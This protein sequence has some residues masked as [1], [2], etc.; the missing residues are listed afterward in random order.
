M[1][2]Q[3]K[4]ALK[5]KADISSD[6]GR[7]DDRRFDKDLEALIKE[8]EDMRINRMKQ[9]RTRGFIA[10]NL[11]I[12]SVLIGVAAFG[13]FFLMEAQVTPAIV[14]LL[15]SFIPTAFVQVWAG[16][17][18]KTYTREHKSVFMPKLAQTLN[19][20]L[21]FHPERGVSAKILEK[22]AVVP[23]H[24]EY[25]AEDC[26]MGTYKGVKVI[27]SEARLYSK[28]H[29]DGA[30]FDGIFVLLETGEDV[31]DGHTIIT[32]NS[33]MVKSYAN[34]RW[35]TM[36]KVHISVSDPDWDKFHIYST[37]PEA[38]EL[39]IGDRLL[40]ELAEAADIFDN[41]D[42]TAVL[43]GKKYVFMMIPYEKDMFE[44][45]SLFVPVATKTQ[46]MQCK[47][48]IEQLLEVI[49]VFDL[50]KPVSTD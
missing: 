19:K 2:I 36:N 49:D 20:G 18:I 38:A 23:A 44:A 30:V 15:A 16:R 43:F 22:L 50:Y 42:L 31:I 28:A 25:K 3:N 9:H 46:A 35:K 32:A 33:K 21:S 5:D 12:F 24:N 7:V 41:A 26:F 6:L 37:K 10:M 48:E 17:P 29:K 34:T 39:M 45:S 11:S 8:S 47:K 40:K 13:W 27:F 1:T 4:T 14:T